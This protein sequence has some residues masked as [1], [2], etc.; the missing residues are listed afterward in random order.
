MGFAVFGRVG[1]SGRKVV[2]LEEVIVFSIFEFYL[3]K[4]VLMTRSV[5]DDFDGKGVSESCEIISRGDGKGCVDFWCLALFYV[6]GGYGYFLRFFFKI[7]I[8]VRG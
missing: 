3:L 1:A 5:Y 2:S 6:N 7:R 8:E 4:I